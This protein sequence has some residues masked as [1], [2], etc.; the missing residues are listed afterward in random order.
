MLDRFFGEP[1]FTRGFPAALARFEEG[2]L[3]LDISETDTHVLVRASVPGF[4]PEDIEAQIHDNVLTLKAEHKEEKE[5]K[6]ERFFRK[7]LKFGSMNRRVA[8]PSHVLDKDVHAELKDGLLTLRIPKAV[9]EAP[10]KI[11]IN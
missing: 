3:P 10:K 7:E 11:R 1:V 6:N 5:E 8:L 2:V 4:K 9:K